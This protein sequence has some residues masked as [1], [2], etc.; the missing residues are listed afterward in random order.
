MKISAETFQ[1]ET[2]YPFVIARAGAAD[3]RSVFLEIAHDGKV[4]LGE[5]HPSSYYYNETPEKVL[6]VVAKV[7]DLLGDDPFP[8]VDIVARITE[9]FPDAPAAVAG[10]DIALHDLCGKLLGVPVYKM[11]AL[12]PANTPRTSYTIGID[13]IDVMLKKLE[14]A[15]EYPILKI[16]VGVDNDMEMIRAIRDNTDAIIRVDA[17]TGWGVDEA[18]EKINA[19]EQFDIELIEQPIKA[20]DYEGLRKIRQNT[21]IPLMADEDSIT[22]AELPKLIGCVDAINIKLM[23]CRGLCEALRMIHTAHSLGMDV[24]LGCMTESSLSLTAAAQLSPLTKYA[25][26]DMNLLLTND[27][28]EGLKVVDGKIILP[29]SPGVGAIRR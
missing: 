1:L 27:P 29:E 18:I 23:K 12:N 16:K 24:M 13:T 21:N 20:G 11:L 26:L 5:A 9:A 4:G 14:E 2:K 17:N 22:T 25:D 8:I 15:R 28:Y 6:E 19:L 10:I 7:G 3:Q